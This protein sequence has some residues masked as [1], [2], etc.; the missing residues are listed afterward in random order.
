MKYPVFLLFFF[1]CV[2]TVVA[3]EKLIQFSGFVVSPVRDSMI[4]VSYAQII[5]K[6]K[7]FGTTASYEGYFSLVAA[8]GDSLIFRCIGFKEMIYI[9]PTTVTSTKFT[10]VQVM[11]REIGKLPEVVIVPWNT[12]SDFR[13]AFVE[14]NI[15]QDELLKAQQNLSRERLDQAEQA[16][17]FDAT[18]ISYYSMQN[19]QSYTANRYALPSSNF[20]NPIAWLKFANAIKN[21]DFKKKKK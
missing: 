16:M 15:N 14:L 10:A 4:P 11:N 13:Y 12:L 8:P 19:Q 9:L 1:G 17:I 18:E 3:E 6:N 5:N 20:T 2:S 7:K 21:G